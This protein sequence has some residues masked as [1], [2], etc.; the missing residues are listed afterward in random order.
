[1]H[2]SSVGWKGVLLKLASCLRRVVANS[3]V[4]TVSVSFGNFC[5]KF[6]GCQIFVLFYLFIFF[7]LV[8][9]LL[10]FVVEEQRQEA[11]R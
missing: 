8:F 5:S 1:M 6:V 9:A 7:L 11:V 10:C 4:D 3:V 2:V